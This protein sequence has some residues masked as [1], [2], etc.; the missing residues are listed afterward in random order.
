MRAAVLK[1]PADRPL[2]FQYPTTCCAASNR[3][4]VPGAVVPALPNWLPDRRE[5]WMGTPL[6]S[7]GC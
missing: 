4:V 5:P 6:A 7:F 3:R 2:N 1:T